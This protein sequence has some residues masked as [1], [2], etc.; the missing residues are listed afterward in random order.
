MSRFVIASPVN[1]KENVHRHARSL[2]PGNDISLRPRNLSSVARFTVGGAEF[3]SQ[4]M[5]QAQ[6]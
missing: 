4:V 1:G 2:R 6:W 5:H 3:L